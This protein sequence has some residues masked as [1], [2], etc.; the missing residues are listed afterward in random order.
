MIIVAGFICAVSNKSKLAREDV[1]TQPVTVFV[2]TKSTAECSEE[3]MFKIVVVSFVGFNMVTLLL[4]VTI[5]KPVSLA[6][7]LGVAVAKTGTLLPLHTG[8]GFNVISLI[9]GLGGPDGIVITTVSLPFT[10]G[11]FT[12]HTNV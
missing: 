3:V 8:F 11:P 6:P 10:Q 9:I 7:K 4:G 12:V 1:C 5:H 2:I